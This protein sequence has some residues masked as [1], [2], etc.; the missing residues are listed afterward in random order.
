MDEP[1]AHLDLMHQIEIL[2]LLK[3]LQREKG[4]T[5]VSVLHDL[6]RAAQCSDSVILF[7]NGKIFAQG[8]PEQLLKKHNIQAVYG[9]AVEYSWEQ[10]LT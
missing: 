7:H 5:V 3:R 2:K 8:S 10:F 1:I 4:L 6:N 9:I